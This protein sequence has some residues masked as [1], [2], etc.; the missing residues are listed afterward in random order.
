MCRVVRAALTAGER[1]QQ[2]DLVAVG[3]RAV[4]VRLERATLAV[5][6]QRIDEVRRMRERLAQRY[7]G[8]IGDFDELAERR[9]GW[10]A[11]VLVDVLPVVADAP[12][13]QDVDLDLIAAQSIEDAHYSV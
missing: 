11:H 2:I 13:D 5:E 3:E 10:H 12:P 4:S 1:R 7:T 9:A 6:H 8:V